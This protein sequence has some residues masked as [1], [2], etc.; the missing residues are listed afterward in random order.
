MT[1]VSHVLAIDLGTSG[2]KVGLVTSA[3][4]VLGADFEPI[5][6][7]LFPNG[8]AEQDP[9]AWWEAICS[10]TRRLI[11]KEITPPDRIEAVAVTSQWS[12]TVAVDSDGTPIGNAI[13]WMDSRG[14][15][16]I[17]ELIGGPVRVEGHD[18][19]KLRQWVKLTGGAPS[20]SG[21]D[22]LAHILYLRNEKPE[23]YRSAATFLE[24]KDYINLLLTGSIAASYDSITLHWVTDNRAPDSVSYSEAL[25]DLAGLDRAQLPPLQPATAILGPLVKEAAT[26]LGLPAGLPVVMGTPDLH[27]AAIGSG[28]TRD[29]AAHLYLGTSSWLISHVPFKKSDVIHSIGSLP[30]AIP[31]RY[32]A[33][34]EQETA[35]KAIEWLADILYPT[36]SD[37]ADVYVEMNRVAAAVPAGSHGVIFTPWLYG[38]RTPVEDAS[39]RGGYFNQSLDTGR[40]E[41]IRAT[42]EGVAYNARWLLHYVEKFV[43]E[44]LDPLVLVGGGAQSDL[45]CQIHADVLGRRVHQAEDPIQVNVRGVGLLAHVALGH[46]SWEDVPRLVPMAASYEPNPANRA[47]YDKAYDAF[48]QLHRRNRRLYRRLN[49]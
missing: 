47:V 3:G 41:M 16:Y 12:G 14:A 46:L 45:W 5:E 37:R 36:E 17:R 19:R 39:L 28:A 49:S 25:L 21:K 6:L 40:E 29:F 23:I 42:F 13:I 8:G 33:A 30:A 1:D 26:D 15:P 32:L 35:G 27:S 31:G 10:A 7:L 4:A 2:P 24:P 44:R 11:A 9:A 20:R 43:G 38:E 34:N 22:P 48:R 18:P